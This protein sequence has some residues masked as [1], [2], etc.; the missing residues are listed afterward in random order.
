MLLQIS[1]SLPR[2]VQ[3]ILAS[4]NP[5]PPLVRANLLDLHNIVLKAREQ[6]L[7]RVRTIDFNI[8]MW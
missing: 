5:I 7:E 8:F 2:E 6:P 4:C 1:E 3:G